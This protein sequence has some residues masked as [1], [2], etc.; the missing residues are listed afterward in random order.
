MPHADHDIAGI[1]GIDPRRH[2]RTDIGWF[3]P[4]CTNWS[5]AKGVKVDYDGKP[6]QLDMFAQTGRGLAARRGR[7]PQPDAHAGRPG[8]TEV[9]R[10]RAL[11]VE[12]VTDVLKW[13][14]G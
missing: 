10:Y 7:S 6:E 11:L 13:S 3:S 2:R 4:E 14:R 1:S 8:I 9:H 5:I 12:H